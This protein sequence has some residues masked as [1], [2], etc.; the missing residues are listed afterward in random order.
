MDGLGIRV[1]CKEWNTWLVGARIDKIHQPD[2]RELVLSVRGS[3]RSGRLL[4]SAHR[5]F[6]R[7]HLLRTT[8]PVNPLEPPMFCMLLRRRIEGG[9]IVAITQPGWERILQIHIEALNDLGDL[10]HFAL[11]LEMMGKHSNLIF[12]TADSSGEPVQVVD[13]VVHV[14]A[15]MSR[16]RQVFPGLRYQS[17]PPQDKLEVSQLSPADLATISSGANSEKALA[18][19]LMSRIHGLG[20]EFVNEVR[21]RVGLDNR[22]ERWL[23]ELQQLFEAVIAGTEQP[24]VGINDLG[25]AIAAAPFSIT[26]TTRSQQTESFD[27]AVERA[28]EDASKR[29]RVTNTYREMEQAIAHQL[30]RLR[31]KR[32]KLEEQRSESVDIDGP[33]S[34]GEI[35]MAYLYRVNKGTAGVEL[36]NFYDE[37][38]PIWIVLDKALTPIQNATH[39][40]KIASK[41]KRS[42]PIVKQELDQ[43][44]ADITYLDGVLAQLEQVDPK[45]YPTIRSE[46]ER[47]GFLRQKSSDKRRRSGNAHAA[48]RRDDIGKPDEFWSVDGLRIRV[49][50]NN[51]QNDRLTLRWSQSDDLW[52]HVKDAPG[53]HVVVEASGDVI[54]DTTIADAAL[55]AAYY[56]KSRNSAKVAVDFTA[57]KH[58][59]KPNGARPGHVLYESQRTVF[60][61]P[62]KSLIDAITARKGPLADT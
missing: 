35:L 41:R 21:C 44:V 39:Y 20:P 34:K 57:T 16:V 15:D 29:T 40:F 28:S 9:R 60:A 26:Y 3:G 54:P 56:S 30:D 12:C 24:S 37:E 46:L 23:T 61:T 45:L 42:I 38:R 4:L 33:R 10:T 62:D 52:F 13:S 8:R 59:W 31:G 18:R 50:R 27:E 43:T 51:L 53:S 58:V 22:P 49:G 47:Q 1:L 6:G 17:P 5:Q 11:V 7:V 14:S 2:A 55:L 48:S 19:N 25:Y 36:P 32:V